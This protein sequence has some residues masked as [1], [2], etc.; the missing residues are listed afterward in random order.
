M[1]GRRTVM[2][3]GASALLMTG[4]RATQS[5]RAQAGTPATRIVTTPVLEATPPAFRVSWLYWDSPFREAGLR[6]GDLIVAVAG[7]PIEAP[8]PGR[9]LQRYVQTAIGQNEEAAGLAALGLGVGAMLALQVRRRRAD[10]GWETIGLGAR[11]AA[12]GFATGPTGR[13]IMGPGGPEEMASDGFG[14]SWAS[15]DEKLVREYTLILDGGWQR[16]T[17]VSRVE[18]R[19][20][21]ERKPRVEA[22]GARWPGPYARAMAADWETVRACLD[23][24]AITLPPD[25]LEFRRAEEEK[26]AKVT[27][28][29]ASAWAVAVDSV[30]ATTIPSFPAAHPIRGDRNAAIGRHVVLPPLGNR[31]WIAEAGHGWFVA[32][33]DSDNRYVID[34]EG[35]EAVAMLR[36]RNRYQRL[37]SPR[38]DAQYQFIGQVME[39]PKMLV[40]GQRAH[41]CLQLK[42]VAAL[43][44]DAMFVD[45]TRAEPEFAGEQEIRVPMGARPADDADPAT[46]MRTLITAAK[47]GD[48]ALWNALFG[49]W[50]V[51][52]LPDGRALLQTSASIP[53]EPWVRTRASLMGRVLDARVSWV[54]EPR[55]VLDGSAY[56]GAPRIEEVDLEI[57]HVGRF[58]EGDRIFTD[59]TV[60]RLWQL[61]R[62][63]LG[64]G[65]GPWRIH[66]VQSI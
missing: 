54:G 32:G 52:R 34:A 17:F 26:V 27:A 18:L 8:A 62:V 22:L 61:Q 3:A 51:D 30:K 58:P 45:L 53:D 56:P 5:A 23:G 1:V 28:I 2:Q 46:V 6:V 39:Q 29:A 38:V 19:R 14:E 21:M 10:A 59:T 31:D 60:N 48:Q 63:D 47:G 12:Q 4:G 37:V 7:R 41:F 11:L 44:G 35:P 15:W 16:K 40:V 43:V 33:N 66:S 36:A 13:R 55:L 24:P 9:A 20:H 57:D 64:R 65:F 50:R 49:A 42:P 25:A